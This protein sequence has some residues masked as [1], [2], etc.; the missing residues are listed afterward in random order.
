[1]APFLT[2]FLLLYLGASGPRTVETVLPAL[3]YGPA[4]WSSV[5][6]Q[7]L[8]DRTVTFAVEAHR[9][10]GALVALVGH[11]GTI[12][13]LKP[14][15]RGSYRPQIEEATAGA[16]VKVREQ[17]AQAQLSPVLSISS[18]IECVAGNEL[19]TVTREVAYPA[20]NP[21]FEGDVGGLHGELVYLVNTS[22]DAVRASACYS[23]GSLFAVP[24]KAPT[25]QLTPVCSNKIDVQI[26]P[27]GSREFPVEGDGTSHLSLTTQGE[28]VVLQ[29]LR[30]LEARIKIYAVDS[31]VTFGSSGDR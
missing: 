31:T 27:Y 14:G 24:G 9:S 26:P 18:T 19:R 20:R 30:P 3:S 22:E 4:C 12:L 28:R 15:E 29:M 13:S 5:D 10:S 8:G 23:S 11:S 2:P 6:L 17:I 25:A 7:N 16:W 1:M 21:W